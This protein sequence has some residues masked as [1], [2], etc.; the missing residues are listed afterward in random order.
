MKM[1]MEKQK[2]ADKK[3]KTNLREI[4]IQS[5]SYLV[6]IGFLGWLGVR[7]VHDHK[8]YSSALRGEIPEKV[9]GLWKNNPSY[10]EIIDV[11][12]DGN[13]EKVFE[14]MVPYR[15]VRMGIYRKP[16]QQEIE[17]YNH[18]YKVYLSLKK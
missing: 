6:A 2:S 15:N 11:D 4:L 10:R 17:W 7:A 8:E 16:S 12:A 1:S 13:P 18:Q 14:N 5:V 9:E 3:G